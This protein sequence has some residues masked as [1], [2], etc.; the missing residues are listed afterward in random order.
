MD[1][2]GDRIPKLYR[3]FDAFLRRLRAT[4]GPDTVILVAS[5]HGH[6]PT[7]L[8][9]RFYSQHRHGPPGIL[10]M[11]GGPVRQGVSLQG[12]DIYDVFPTVLY[13]LG[14]PVPRDIPGQPMLDALDP[15]FVRSH[16]MR[17]IDT[18]ETLGT[19][20]GLSG[21]GRGDELNRQEIEKL[22]SLGYL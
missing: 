21:A 18:Y 8:H 15:A 6:A 14:L 2:N 13:L 20:R 16:P 17:T 19:A 1:E 12:K 7:I 22:K 3:D 4:V 11:Q 10:L 5:D 9:G